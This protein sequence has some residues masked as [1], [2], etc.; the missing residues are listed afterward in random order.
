MKVFVEELCFTAFE[1]EGQWSSSSTCVSFY[2]WS[3]VLWSFV[4]F[5]LELICCFKKNISSKIPDSVFI[6]SCLC[7]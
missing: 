1:S 2:R 7:G 3:G 6:Y 5:P 4:G